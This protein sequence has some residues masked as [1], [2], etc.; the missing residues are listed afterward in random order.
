MYEEL[1]TEDEGVV[2]TEHEKIMVLRNNHL[3]NGYGDQEGYRRWLMGGIEELVALA[4]LHDGC[5]IREKLG[6]MIPEYDAQDS[7]CV[8]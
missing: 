7:E 2:E 3:W 1:I 5:G 4:K 6:E 8:I